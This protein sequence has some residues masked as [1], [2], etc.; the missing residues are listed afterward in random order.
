MQ[1]N[2]ELGELLDSLTDFLNNRKQG[3]QLNN[4]TYE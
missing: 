1:L 2:G 3:V 4:Q